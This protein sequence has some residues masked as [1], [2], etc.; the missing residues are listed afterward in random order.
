V[1]IPVMEIKPY[2]S[3]NPHTELF[4]DYSVLEAGY[5][6]KPFSL[7]QLLNDCLAP[8]SRIYPEVADIRGKLQEIITCD[9]ING[10][11]EEISPGV[12][13]NLV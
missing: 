5:Q 10:C 12:Y 6:L 1:D 2:D 9:I 4:K 11:L 3:S 8:L 13:Q 7:D